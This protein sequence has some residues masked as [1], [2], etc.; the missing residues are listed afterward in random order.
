MNQ[1]R[2]KSN[3]NDIEESRMIIYSSGSSRQIRELNVFGKENEFADYQFKAENGNSVQGNSS[4]NNTICSGSSWEQIPPTDQTPY[5]N[6][7]SVANPF[8]TNPGVKSPRNIDAVPDNGDDPNDVT[9][10]GGVLVLV[11]TEI[12]FGYRKVK[13]KQ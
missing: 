9:L 8:G 10:D 2:F 11:L 13:S 12:T 6:S 1:T 5:V 7:P 4:N 3:F